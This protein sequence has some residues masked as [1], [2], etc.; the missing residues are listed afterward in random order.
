M[1]R[2]NVYLNDDVLS[3]LNE[4]ADA[5]GV[6]RSAWLSLKVQQE[7]DSYQGNPK[8]KKDLAFIKELVDLVGKYSLDLGISAEQFN[9]KADV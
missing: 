9:L 7:Y 1:A 8:Y 2:V 6:N 5:Y 4:L 3:Q